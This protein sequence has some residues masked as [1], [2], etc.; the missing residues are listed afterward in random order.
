MFYTVNY[1][2][3]EI[4]VLSEKFW[5]LKNAIESTQVYSASDEILITDVFGTTVYALYK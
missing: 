4:L 3:D 5:F 1:Y 2:I